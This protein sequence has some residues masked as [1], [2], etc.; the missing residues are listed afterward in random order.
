MIKNAGDLKEIIRISNDNFSYTDRDA[1]M[2][3]ARIAIRALAEQMLN[4]ESLLSDEKA[5][6]KQG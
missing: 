6:K 1:L 2:K 3:I 5:N 4:G